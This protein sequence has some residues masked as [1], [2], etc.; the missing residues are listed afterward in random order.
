MLLFVCSSCACKHCFRFVGAQGC[1]SRLLLLLLN[2]LTAADVLILLKHVVKMFQPAAAESRHV[3]SPLKNLKLQ[4]VYTAL[5]LEVTVLYMGMGTALCAQPLLRRHQGSSKQAN[6]QSFVSEGNRGPGA[7]M[8]IVH[9]DKTETTG[10]VT[11]R[12]NK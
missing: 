9:P 7:D 5:V 3:G 8:L 2:N 10:P 4:L 1:Q 6:N 11:C 12:L